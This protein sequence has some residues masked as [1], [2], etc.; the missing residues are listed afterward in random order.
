MKTAIQKLLTFA[1]MLGCIGAQAATQIVG[2]VTITNTPAGLSSNIV[3]NIGSADTRYW[4]NSVLGTPATSIQTTNSTAASATNLVAHLTAYP[5]YSA[6]AGTPQLLAT[7]NSTNTSVVNLYAPDNTNLTVTFGGNWAR[8][9]YVTNTFADGVPILNRTNSMGSVARTNAENAIVNLL[10]INRA[11]NQVPL[12][13]AFLSK[14]VDTNTAQTIGNKTLIGPV[15]S[16]GRFTTLTNL[17]G[18]NVA[19]TNVVLRLVSVTGADLSGFVTALTNGTIWSNVVEYA[20]IT[21]AFGLHGTVN[22]FTSGLWTNATLDRPKTTNLVNRG[23][24]ISSPN[25]NGAAGENFGNAAAATGVNSTAV[26]RNALSSG[27]SSSAFGYNSQ[28]TNS[29]STATGN[30]A[31]SGGSRSASYGTDSVATGQDASAFGAASVASYDY[32]TAVGTA[33]TTTTTNQVRI[34]KSDHTVS[35]PG[36]LWVEGSITN[37]T[38]RGTNTINGRLDLTPRANSSLANGYN[39]G[40]VL[41]TNVYVRMS[42]PSGAYTN[43]GFAASAAVDGTFHIVQ[44]DNPGLSFTI[45]NNSG[46]DATAANRVYTGTGALKNSTN[47][48]VVFKM[49][50]DGNVSRWRLFDWPPN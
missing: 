21:N 8:V 27:N 50:Y 13:S 3:V 40:V 43:V 14:Y 37:A 36:Q 29:S 31:V 38:I 48:P 42:G 41:G 19:L 16:G 45:L 10:A 2:Y 32:S 6:G 7:L 44:A 49:I 9:V 18:T 47:N 11:T 15:L 30:N 17:T 23:D 46:L 34:G 39:S 1:L 25:T 12:A 24:A 35:I 28:A 26:G 20:R 33:V 4:T 5:V 22:K